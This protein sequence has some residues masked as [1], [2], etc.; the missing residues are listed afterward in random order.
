MPA[1]RQ[2]LSDLTL[3]EIPKLLT[4]LDRNRHSPTYGC[5][6]RNYWH[7]RIID[8]PSGM[9]QEFVWPLALACRLPI[10]GN[11][12]FRQPVLR[13]HAVAALHYA[14]RSAHPDGSCDDY[15]PYERAAGAAVFSLLGCMD[16]SLLLEVRDPELLA[17]FRKRAHWLA[18]HEESGRL[19]NHE[20]LITLALAMAASVT[21]DRSLSEA[22]DRRWLRL[23][24]WYVEEEGWFPEYEGLDPGYHSLT[25]SA[26]AR[27][28]QIKPSDSLRRVLKQGT[29]LALELV[30]PDGSYGGEYGSRNTYSFFPHGFELIGRWY[31]QALAVN[32]RALAGL[33]RGMG[34]CFNDDHIIGHHLWNYLLAW[35][36]YRETRPAPIER[37]TRCWLPKAGLLIDRR[38]D[39]ELYLS[40]AKGG[41]YKLY[42]KGRLAESDTQVSALLKHGSGTRNAVGHLRDGYE[43][44]VDTDSIEVAG[45]LGYAK[46]GRMT[47]LRMLVLRV[48]ML[49]IGRYFPNL[50]RTLLQ[51][52]LITGKR[53]APMRFHRRLEWKAGAWECRD[54]L[55]CG[56]WDSVQR[57]LI[58]NDQT[59][60]YIAMSRTYADGQLREGTDLTDVARSL[61]KGETLTHRRR[62]A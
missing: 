7:Y 28:Y 41:V 45:S 14:A 62:Y 36:D 37:R 48:L 4:L 32:D 56:D 49:T 9:A 11:P 51:T 30:H 3:P 58:G 31:P 20:A 54:T 34:P 52:M 18:S 61:Q 47:P 59:S 53:K 17:F 39:D 16:A 43:V 27:L 22:S 8:F 23:Q 29:D 38:A 46:H 13:E 6:D 60:I 35:R 40:A 21:G 42:R 50:I 24:S 10:P 12:Y 57:L 15:Y 55:A 44:T 2:L 26:L 5:F 25:L 33:A 19:S 1:H